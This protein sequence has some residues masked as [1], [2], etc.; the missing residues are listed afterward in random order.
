MLTEFMGNKLFLVFS[1]GPAGAPACR[2][3]GPFH[4]V[5]FAAKGISAGE[6]LSA[7]PIRIATQAI[8]NL[9]WEL[10][11]IDDPPWG[12][13]TVIAPPMPTTSREIESANDWIR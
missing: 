8:D 5:R 9:S 10:D 1:S 12:D 11:G 13:V 4:Y 3:L 6:K 7:N 2:V